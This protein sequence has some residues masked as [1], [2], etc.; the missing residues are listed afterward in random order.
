MSN[1]PPT[2]HSQVGG[3]MRIGPFWKRASEM[4]PTALS[5]SG[6]EPFDALTDLFLGEV[7]GA[8]VPGAPKTPGRTEPARTTKQSR[9]TPSTTAAT[10]TTHKPGD[11]PILRLAGTDDDVEYQL[12]PTPNAANAEAI[13]T[14]PAAPVLMLED[15]EG[16]ARPILN[17]LP[18]PV[19][20]PVLELLVLGNLPVLA[21]AWASQY[22]REIAEAVGKPVA[23][24]RMQ[25]EF[26][27]LEIVGA[28]ADVAAAPGLG[29]LGSI[30]DAID[31]A[32]E[33]TDRWIVRC[34]TGQEASVVACPITRA[35]TILTG[36]D[37]T[38]R[39]ACKVTLTGL[40]ERLPK[41]SESG[42]MVRLAVM[43]GQ[44]AGAGT[45]LAAMATSTL[46]RPVAAVTCAGKIGGVRPP[47]AMFSGAT[48]LTLKT[49]LSGV[50]RALVAGQVGTDMFARPSAAV[51]TPIADVRI[52]APIETVA[53]EVEHAEPSPV[54]TDMTVAE[55]SAELASLA[56][57]GVAAAITMAD[58]ALPEPKSTV[59]EIAA[60]HGTRRQV[61]AQTVEHVERAAPMT[62]AISTPVGPVAMPSVQMW[63]NVA[64]PVRQAASNPATV[65]GA[66]DTLASHLVDL[67][68]TAVRCPYAT[69]IEVAIDG[70]GRLHLL[71]R[72][73]AASS[74]EST[75]AALLIASSWAE[76]HAGI[77]A[78]SLGKQHST[79]R[80]TLHLFTDQPKHSRRLL[81]TNLRV[82]LLAEVHV[83]SE[84]AWYCTDLN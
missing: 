40:A 61:V 83:G 41:A 26:V 77:L 55:G 56:D 19:R 7:A 67:Q 11:G 14:R 64:S 47:H 45:E 31:A 29:D 53:A 24:L 63:S 51:A 16:E 54:P 60:G 59:A 73:K 81:E 5:P 22:V 36:G 17:A 30:D 76:T 66:V 48:E 21:G 32:A 49:I 8:R 39:E 1:I 33:I 58:I 70:A 2:S 9:P 57:V 62:A 84:R 80:P 4:A 78:S 10:P 13:A 37:Q 38:A 20:N 52:P 50:E 34:D 23:Y 35:V 74:E 3:S 27:S 12:A 79:V 71:A 43:G 15:D 42:P 69:G 28:L 68:S 44:H 18:P 75:L 65:F 46:A 6:D 82:H 25:G 72:A